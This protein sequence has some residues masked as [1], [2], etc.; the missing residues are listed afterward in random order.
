MNTQERAQVDDLRKVLHSGLNVLVGKGKGAMVE[1]DKYIN[2]CRSR[3]VYIC[4]FD[5]SSFS[6]PVIC[7]SRTLWVV[8]RLSVSISLIR[9]YITGTQACKH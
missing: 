3:V 5:A 8:N 4:L 7:A 2:K 6:P 9:P 1:W